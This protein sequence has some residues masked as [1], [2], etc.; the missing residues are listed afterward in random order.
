[1]GKETL[2]KK[3]WRREKKKKTGEEKREDTLFKK[4]SG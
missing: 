4:S 3:L 2:P 1:M